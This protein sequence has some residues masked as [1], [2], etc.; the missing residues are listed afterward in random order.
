[1]Q[2]LTTSCNVIPPNGHSSSVK[3]LRQVNLSPEFDSEEFISPTQTVHYLL[4]DYF[5]ETPTKQD[6]D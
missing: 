6:V 2:Y 3:I 4:E 5:P 1:M